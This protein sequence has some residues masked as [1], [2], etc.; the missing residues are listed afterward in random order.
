MKNLLRFLGFGNCTYCGHLTRNTG[1]CGYCTMGVCDNCGFGFNDS[2]M[3]VQCAL[4][5]T[6]PENKLTDKYIEKLS[7]EYLRDMKGYKK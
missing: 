4:M 6:I 7:N 5:V 2:S 1:P 3:H